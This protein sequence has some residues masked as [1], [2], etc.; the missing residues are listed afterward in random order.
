MP[1]DYF[2]VTDGSIRENGCLGVCVCVC[3]KARRFGG[4][5]GGG[6]GKTHDCRERC[7]R[8]MQVFPWLVRQ[9]GLGEL[10][11]GERHKSFSFFLFTTLKTRAERE[12]GGIIYADQRACRVGRRGVCVACVVWFIDRCLH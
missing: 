3:V 9:E 11:R 6:A 1:R 8:W 5:H 10:K 4:R 7:N 12:Q 2:D